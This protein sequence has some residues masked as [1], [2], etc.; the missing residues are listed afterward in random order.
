MPTTTLHG[1]DVYKFYQSGKT[2]NLEEIS[3]DKELTKHIQEI[4]INLDLVAPPV[5]GIFG[6]MTREAFL[7]FQKYMD[8]PQIGILDPETA[9]KLVETDKQELLASLT[10]KLRP[11]NDL[12]GRI[13]KYML[14]KQYHIFME[15]RRYN[16][17]YVEGM[18]ADGTVNQDRANYFN[19][20]RIVIEVIDGVP[21]IVGNWEATTEPSS[22]WTINPMTP[23]GAAR[24][25][26]NQFKAW[27]V[28][29][30]KTQYPALVQVQPITVYRDW[31]KDGFRTSDKKDT[32]LFGINQHHAD[33]A[34]TNNI[35]YWSAGCLVGRS[36]A[37]HN[38]FMNI[39]MKDK[40]YQ[41]SNKYT[42]ETTIIPGD[43]LY[44][45]F[46]IT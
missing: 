17:V 27:R 46:P 40:C 12:A 42:F 28:G 38:E 10:S 22:H 21:K 3:A 15:P 29:R 24:I 41:L 19:D 32:G 35:G 14:D 36:K 26:F 37:E 6:P 11:G 23:Q 33:N 25:E 9:K 45:K 30:H 31:N 4:L 44:N 1:A 34:P 5:D 20:R 8:C 7:E 16:I 43:D 2:Y 18:N 13:I 39:I